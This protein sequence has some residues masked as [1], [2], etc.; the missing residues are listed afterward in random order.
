MDRKESAVRGCLLG[1]AVGDAM[2][3]PV[4]K[5]SWTQ[6]VEDYGP[7]G[8]L[9]YDLVN[10]TADI[11]SH[12]QL[13]AFVCNGI[14]LGMT[15]R[16]PDQFSKFIILSLREWARSQQFR[17]V[18]ER[19]HCWLAQEPH[20]RRRQCMDTRILDALAR[21]Q[22]GT[23][24]MPIFRSETPAMLT[25]AVAVGLMYEPELMRPD[26]IGRLAA[27]AVATTHGDPECFLSGAVLA[28]AVAGVLQEP[29][30]SLIEQFTGA[31]E[32]VMAQ[33]GDRYAQVTTVAK[34]VDKAIRYSKDPEL[35]PLA[36]MSMLGCS[37]ALECLAGT[38]YACII[39]PANFDEGM[40][41]AV[42][43]SGRSAATGALVG[44]ILGARLGDEALPEFYLESLETQTI[45]TE[46]ATDISQGRQ[47][48]RVFDADWDQK[49]VHGMPIKTL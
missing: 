26:M 34:A 31:T 5:K 18:A 11:T 33:F 35:S 14:L 13:A 40:I 48:M 21:E 44:A 8:L 46:L 2:G 10:G 37:T 16:K 19:T 47:L 41:A 4:D 25:S 20:M 22:L 7:N 49:Y 3:Y 6:I 12:T 15:R 39:H 1:M 24:E 9:G 27:E 23:P 30:K 36:A 32:T 17:T 29:E 28:Y 43:H 38:V 45:L 42:N